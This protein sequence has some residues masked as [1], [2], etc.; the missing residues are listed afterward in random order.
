[1]KILEISAKLRTETGKA[2]SKQLRKS[3]NVPCII[4]GGESNIN[5]YAHRNAFKELIYTPDAHIVHLDIEGKKIK[6]VLKDIQFHPVSDAILHI[7][8]IEVPDSKPIIINIPIKVVGDSPGV[9][10]G[11]KLRI[12]SR[13]L[14]VKGLLNDIPEFLVVDISQLKIGHSIKVGDLSYDK[15]ELL[16]SKTHLILTVATTRGVAKDEIAEG[17]EPA[18]E[19]AGTEAAE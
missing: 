8:F 6:A 9:K 4:Y 16:D 19:E 14:K 2:G 10:A 5:F 1:M 17:E 12:K 13:N 18:A 11:G 7:D 15:I 3:D